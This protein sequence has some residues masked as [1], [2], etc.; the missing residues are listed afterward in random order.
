MTILLRS[1]GTQFVMQAYR[2]LL[3]A[4]KKS[5]LVQEIRL[6]SE[7]QGPYVRLFNRGQRQ[8]EA[9]F[10]TEPG[11][12]FGE[13]VW[14][15]FSCPQNLI[16]CEAIPDSAQILVVVVRSDSVYIDS[17]ILASNLQSELLPLMTADLKYR[18]FTSGNVPLREVE[19]FGNFCFPTNLIETFETLENPLFSRLP[20]SKA[21]QLQPLSLAL[22]SEHLNFGFSTLVVIFVAIIVVAGGWWL[23]TS[24]ED[25][26]H[27]P[28]VVLQKPV[29]AHD[30]YFKALLFPDPDH[31][32]QE[33][34]GMLKELCCLPGWRLSELDYHHQLYQLRLH[35]EGGGLYF[36]ERWAED[37]DYGFRLSTRGL[38]LSFNSRVPI[39]AKPQKMDSLDHVVT[40]LVD[41]LG[42]VLLQYAISFGAK[43]QHGNIQEEP[44]TIRIKNISPDLLELVGRQ[45]V[46][47][48]VQLTS[49]MFHLQSGLVSGTIGLSVWGR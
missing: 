9:V 18:I 44:L 21:L 15:F 13:S 3:S 19:S 28:P 23:L 6:L 49:V 4:K 45:L 2:E 36:L 34:I 1:D 20:V 5:Q 10:S 48:P 16:Y 33:I 22:E 42:P 17:R 29:N 7:Q 35:S 40:L 43:R 32:F 27:Q 26:V 31:Q 8:Y 24:R 12:L 30:M 11:Y 25:I 38:Q 14:N 46:G 41:Q 37:H 47:L 39:R